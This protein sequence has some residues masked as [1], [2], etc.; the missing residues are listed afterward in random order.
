MKL[1]FVTPWFGFDI[2]GGAEAELRGLAT[3]LNATDLE[4]EILT[5]CV[6]DFNSDWNV[7]FHK[8]GTT[9]ENGL[10]IQRFR[11]DKRDTNKFNRVNSRL[12]R[13]IPLTRKD[14]EIYIDEMINS[15]ALYEYLEL[16]QDD[17]DLFV[18]IPYMFGTT[19]NGIK[20]NP[21]KSVLIPCFHDESYFQMEIFKELYSNIAGM[22]FHAKPEQQLVLENYD[23]APDLK[24]K[25]LGEGVDTGFTYDAKRFVDKYKIKDPFILYAGRKEAG[26]RVDVLLKYFSEYKKRNSNKLKLVLIGGGKIKIPRDVKKDV[27]DLGFVDI[28]DKYDAYGAAM[29]LCQ[30]SN[31]E[32]FSLVIMES[33][34]ANRPVIV[35]GGCPVTKNFAIESQ[36]GLYFDSYFDFEGTVNYLLD[37]SDIANKM[38]QAG[39]DFV[40]SNFEW[41]VI[42][43]KY[44]EMFEEIVRSKND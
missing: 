9:V 7:N 22:I 35:S 29:T 17:Y 23:L 25:V 27:Y 36:G 21:K 8:E 28:Q 14:E 43:E 33:W 30:P 20:V 41:N 42:V 6:K 11:I 4:I 44:T 34:L 24:H 40:N 31:S 38:G 2:P 3:H 39:Y 12:M 32:S 5:T 1:G 16:N 10:K 13:S 26:K 37:N 18:F 15:S 19:Y